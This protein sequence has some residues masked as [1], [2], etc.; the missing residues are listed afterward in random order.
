[1]DPSELLGSIEAQIEKVKEESM[2]RKE[3]MDRIDKWLAACE[4]E[5]WLEEYNLVSIFTHTRT[6]THFCLC[7]H[8]YMHVY[9][10]NEVC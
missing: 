2:S 9:T 7:T 3:I 6:H 4:E 5:S 1:M 8:I 10:Y